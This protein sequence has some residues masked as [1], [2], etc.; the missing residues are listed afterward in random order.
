MNK[1]FSR[2][3][4]IT[5]MSYFFIAQTTLAEEPLG[6]YECLYFNIGLVALLETENTYFKRSQNKQYDEKNPIA[7][8]LIILK[9]RGGA[10]AVKKNVYVEAAEYSLH[11]RQLA[12]ASYFL[13][14]AQEIQLK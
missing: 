12:N 14:K 9:N 13:Q 7:Q 11:F 5:L 2:I 1:S 8:A 10:C 6:E 3:L 4:P